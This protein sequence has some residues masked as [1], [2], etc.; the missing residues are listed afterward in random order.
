MVDRASWKRQHREELLYASPDGDDN[1]A[2]IIWRDEIPEL[3]DNE[4]FIS[5]FEAWHGFKLYDT[6]PF[7]GGYRDQ[8]CQ[9][10]DSIRLL[11]GM[12]NEHLEQERR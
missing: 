3:L 12:Y 11:E 5:V 9:W 1:K 2:V 8:P 10:C 6:L 7:I 4:Y